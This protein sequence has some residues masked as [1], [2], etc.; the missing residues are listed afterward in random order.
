MALRYQREGYT[1]RADAHSFA[2][3]P[4]PKPITLGRAELE[5]LGL[6]FRDDY[7]LRHGDTDTDADK[8]GVIE[9]IMDSLTNVLS[10]CRSS[11]DAWMY[12]NLERAMILIGGMD[13]E[14]VR[15]MFDQEGV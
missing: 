3:T 11:K 6:L 2:I 12:R 7:Q 14:Q 5:Q 8:G 9:A 4:G 1:F 13:E 10:R 15:E